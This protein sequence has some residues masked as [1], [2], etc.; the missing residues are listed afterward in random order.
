ME[1]DAVKALNRRLLLSSVLAERQ[2]QIK[3]AQQ[4]KEQLAETEKRFIAD[5]DRALQV[6][7]FSQ[8]GT[9]P[10]PS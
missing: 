6:T 1:T 4:T 5:R 10:C 2:N 8:P 9:E 7:L 3:Q